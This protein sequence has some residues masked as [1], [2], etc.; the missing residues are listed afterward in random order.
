[1]QGRS[2]GLT[3]E[4]SRLIIAEVI[5]QADPREVKAALGSCSLVCQSWEDVA[6]TFLFHQFI[7]KITR[8]NHPVLDELFEL[9]RTSR[10]RFG[11]HIRFLH[12]DGEWWDH[13]PTSSGRHYDRSPAIDPQ[14]LQILIPHLPRLH[15]LFL[16]NIRLVSI[17]SGLRITP[18][19]RPAIS[20]LEI[21]AEVAEDDDITDIFHVIYGFSSI[22]TL[23]LHF[24]YSGPLE[25]LRPNPETLPIYLGSV[26]VG[27]LLFRDLLSPWARPIHDFLRKVQGPRKNNFD[28][29]CFW[30]DKTLEG[31]GTFLRMVGPDVRSLRLNTVPM[32]THNHHGMYITSRR[33]RW[34]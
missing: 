17:N 9:L 19:M 6:R 27:A 12:L 25:I 21:F 22:K 33:W 26:N 23:S 4:L 8:N 7:L 16:T 3:T 14:A 34:F 2:R 10:T 32:F 1:M 20:R 5:R 28:S 18:F 13:N 30:P 29:V 31:A 24:T 15:S 11:R